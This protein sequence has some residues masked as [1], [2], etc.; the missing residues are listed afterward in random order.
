MYSD[1]Y[2]EYLEDG[3]CVVLFLTE[4]SIDHWILGTNFIR[5]YYG[6]F[7]YANK[8]IGFAKSDLLRDG[9]LGIETVS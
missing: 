1:D 6:I 5:A 8:V 3:V 4:P 2:L 7:D 9:S